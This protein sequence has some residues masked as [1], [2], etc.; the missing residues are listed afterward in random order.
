[1][2][3]SAACFVCRK[4]RGESQVPGGVLYEDDLVFATHGVLQDGATDGYPGVL[5][6]EPRRHVP[7]MSGLTR[8]EA[9][10]VGLLT[11]RLSRA[12][13]SCEGVERTYIA[14]AGHHVPHLHVW[15]VPRYGGMPPDLWGLELL[16]SP[17]APRASV[18]EIEALCDRVRSF[19]VQEKD[20]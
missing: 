20:Q 10:R 2:S 12:L 6:V 11:S 9:E 18:S 7:G 17:D 4:H 13:E 1:M 14:V 15:L 16:R 5:F 8:A 19:L 3:A